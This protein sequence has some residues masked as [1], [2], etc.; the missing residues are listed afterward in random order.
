MSK[1]IGLSLEDAAF[2]VARGAMQGAQETGRDLALIA[3]STMQGTISG[4]REI[5]GDVLTA[6]R[7]STHGLIKG[8]AEVGGD[9]TAVARKAVEGAVAGAKKVGVKLE[10][11]ASAA[12]SGAVEA[13]GEISES[14]A[15]AVTKAVSGT[16]SG[17][18]VVLR[19][20]FKRHVI[21]A[22]DS[23]R[24]NLELLRQQLGREG[25]EMRSATSLEEI[26][27]VIKAKDE[28][29]LSLIDLSG[30]DQRIWE[31]CQKLR[32]A[33]IPVIVIAPQRSPTIQRESMKYGASGLLVK[34]VGIKDLVEHIQT[35]L[36]D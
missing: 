26:D 35:L 8:T 18:K 3:K 29:T 19:V 11:A 7:S 22:V 5:G 36:G 34:P 20:P 10:D 27:Q 33:K 15:K 21:L 30:F 2:N 25:Y 4:T 28:I 24:S 12:A 23:N 1:S 6:I 9:V 14:T 16:I 32:Q 13:A 17:V 31:R